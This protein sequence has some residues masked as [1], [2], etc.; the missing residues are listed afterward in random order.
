LFATQDARASETFWRLMEVMGGL[1]AQLYCCSGD[2]IDDLLS[3]KL[4]VAYNVLGSYAV[5]RAETTDALTVILPSEFPTM[6]MRTALVS[7]TAPD[8]DLAEAFVRHLVAVQ[9]SGATDLPLPP[10]TRTGQGATIGL[11]PALM[12]YLDRMKRQTFVREW[13]NALVQTD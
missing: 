1:N 10:L 9:S 6:M 4:L 3:G 13:E 5:A 2:M 12:T 11:D 7:R 8:R